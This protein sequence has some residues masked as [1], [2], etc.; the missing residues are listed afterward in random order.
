MIVKEKAFA[1]LNLGLT[2]KPPERL[3]DGRTLHSM[4][5][6]AAT[7]ELHNKF[8]FIEPS[9]D[10]IEIELITENLNILKLKDLLE[11]PNGKCWKTVEYLEKITGKKLPIKIVMESIL[12]V[13][14][15]VGGGS[16]DMAAILR[17][18]NVFYNLNYSLDE[19]AQIGF[20]LGSD[21]PFCVYNYP[22][23]SML[24]KGDIIVPLNLK[25]EFE[26]EVLIAIP[27]VKG[28][29]K[30]KTKAAFEYLD[31][32]YFNVPH[33]FFRD[34]ETFERSL[35]EGIPD[36]N[37]LNNCFLHCNLPWANDVLNVMK[38]LYNT[39]N[40]VFVGMA[41]AGP[42]VFALF[43]SDMEVSNLPLSISNLNEEEIKI[44]YHFTKVLKK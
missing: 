22:F 38:T 11:G 23:A 4:L 14:G 20:S 16:A 9:I 2:F 28:I 33:S 3:E 19:L 13:P 29:P 26:Y 43:K 18:L 35:I 36:F 40:F 30:E 7:L 6:P 1:K 37:L 39:N 10:G 42:T 12:P 17:G 27:D 24:G 8:T 31:E 34:F 25:T 21:V 32:Y 5:S 15:G 41:G 44:D